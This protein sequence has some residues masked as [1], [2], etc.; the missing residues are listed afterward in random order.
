MR[1][2]KRF[3]KLRNT[4]LPVCFSIVLMLNLPLKCYAQ[5]TGT[6]PALEG[7]AVEG[8]SNEPE[9]DSSLTEEPKVNEPDEESSDPENPEA[10]ETTG[11]E[12]GEASIAEEVTFIGEE[13]T[14]IE[15]ETSGGKEAASAAEEE[16]PGVEEETPGTEE[17]TSGVEEVMS[18]AEGEI[19]GGEEETPGTE[20]EVSEETEAEMPGGEE[21]EISGGEEAVF[22]QELSMAAASEQQGKVTYDYNAELY[23]PETSHDAEQPGGEYPGVYSAQINPNNAAAEDAETIG[24]PSIADPNLDKPTLESP[25]IIQGAAVGYEEKTGPVDYTVIKERPDPYTDFKYS[26]LEEKAQDG[27]THKKL[28]GFDGTYVILRLNVENFFSE[29]SETASNLYLHVKQEKNLA[30]IPG[31][32]MMDNDHA[33]AD[34]LGSKTGS[35]RLEDL[36]D[37]KGRD[38]TTPYVDVLLF[39]TGKLAAGADSGKTDQPDGDVPIHFYMDDVADYNPDLK[40]DPQS[41]DPNHHEQCLAKFFDATKAAV[42]KISN[43]LIKGSDLALEVAAENSGG[44]NKDTGTTYWSVKK[45]FEDPYYDLPQDESKDDPEC[46]RTLKMI[47]EVPVVDGLTFEGTDENHLRKRTLDVNSFDIQVANNTAQNKS[48]YTDGITLRNAWLTIEDKSNTTGAEM[49]IGNNAQFV[50]DKGGKLIIDETCQLEIEWDGATTTPAADGTTPSADILNNGL[51]DLRAGGEIVNNG[52]ITIEG[53]EGKPYQPGTGQQAADSEKG[54]GEFTIEKGAKLTNNG[55]LVVYGRLYNLGTLVN[56]GKYDDVIR[57]YD[58]DKGWFDYHKGIQISWKDDVTQNNVEPGSLFNGKD[59][60]GKIEKSAI[61][62]NNGDIL[63]NPGVLE[64]YALLINQANA[65]IYLAAA[66]EAIIPIEPT[67]QAP[68]VVSKR[69]TLCPPQGSSFINY[70]TLINDGNIVPATVELNDNGSFGAITTPGEH[71]ELFDFRNEGTVI[72]NGYIYGWP[73]EE[74]GSSG[75]TAA[76]S[77]S[78]GDRNEQMINLYIAAIVAALCGIIIVKRRQKQ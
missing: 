52:I 10:G 60:N 15:E 70:G 74:G 67:A 50:I 23:A 53:T 12:A 17:E 58:P 48:T 1:S 65:N 69:I 2:R 8:I 7:A 59:R 28:S 34:A 64:N 4:L 32:G 72:N 38:L 42:D 56:N 68:T 55:S 3:G 44:E 25:A 26:I 77:M 11:A 62:Q 43:F 19:S 27:S 75:V 37:Q 29:V 9:T 66:T 30:L 47:S 78:T 35:Y 41:T 36:L 22:R 24:M 31:M 76:V 73:G 54:Y 16:T 14:A 63:L 21:A 33:F 18:A 71:P 46:G 6:R 61:L 20:A 45:A 51:L 5:E 57:S 13:E 39:S 49:A 40:Y